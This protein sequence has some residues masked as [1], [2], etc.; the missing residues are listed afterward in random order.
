MDATGVL[1]CG[2]WCVWY[3]RP[4]PRRND[5]T[6]VKQKDAINAWAEVAGPYLIDVAK[7]KT[8]VTY[9]AL[10]NYVR[11]A[12][13]IH[14]RQLILR[15]RKT[16]SAR[17]AGKPIACEVCEFDFA[18]VYG[19]R[20]RDCCEVHHRTPLHESGKTI[21]RLEDL[22]ILCANCHRMIH[23]YTPWLAV[24]ELADLVRRA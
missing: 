20:G 5:G 24:E 18:V 11:E 6:E 13:G 19:E 23:R 21:T 1:P 15:K 12:A 4:T 22:A 8:T 9:K 16:H 14:T 3:V 7:A 10:A 17:K 2:S